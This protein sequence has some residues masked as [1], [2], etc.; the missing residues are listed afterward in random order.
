MERPRHLPNRPEEPHAPASPESAGGVVVPFPYR[1]DGP[2]GAVHPLHGD[3][4]S[5]ADH[6]ARHIL[7]R[8]ARTALVA[9][10][11]W[12]AGTDPFASD[13][14]AERFLSH[15]AQDPAFDAAARAYTRVVQIALTEAAALGWTVQV[16]RLTTVHLDSAGLLVVV[17]SGTVRTAFFP[18]I[19]RVATDLE[20][21]HES[22]NERAAREARERRWSGDEHHY[23]R[24]FRPAMRTVRRFPASGVRGDAQYGALKRV[25]PKLSEL[26]LAEWQ[27]MRARLGHAAMTR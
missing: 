5:L 8:D 16:D 18:G 1:V 6:L 21:R 27:S 11:P 24:V 14:T 22:R 3:L 17:G 2:A 7:A 26:G 20:L 19:D 25:L 23:Y 12:L 10:H 4:A 15:R 13:A 9:A